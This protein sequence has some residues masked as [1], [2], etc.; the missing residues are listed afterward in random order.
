MRCLRR[1]P[2]LP[3]S[4]GSERLESCGCSWRA[5]NIWT[6]GVITRV[7]LQRTCLGVAL[8]F[9]CVVTG[10]LLFAAVVDHMGAF[11]VDVKPINFT[12]LAGLALVVVGAFLVQSSNR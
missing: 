9:V 1:L 8:F 6:T 10:Q 5:G 11:G 4:P 12:K 3:I 7:D 2:V